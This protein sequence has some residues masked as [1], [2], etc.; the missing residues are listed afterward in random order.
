MTDEEAIQPEP[1]PTSD[2][3]VDEPRRHRT[4]T[5][6]QH[7]VLA[8]NCVIVVVCFAAAVGLIVGKRAAEQRQV[9]AFAAPAVRAQPQATPGSGPVDTGPQETFPAADPAV[10]NFLLVGADNNACIDPKSPYA[11]G[12]ASTGHNG[13]TDTIMVIRVDSGNHRAAVLS[14]PRDLWVDVPGTGKRRI[15]SAYRKNDPSVL[16]AVLHD[17]FAIDIDHFVQVDFCA[18]VH[19]VQAVGG[20]QVPLPYAMRDVSTGFVTEVAGC[21]RFVGDEALA[22]VRSRHMEYQDI[23]NEWHKDGSSDFGR[24]ARQQDFIRR[25]LKAI[26]DGGLFNPTKIQGL[27]TS[28]KNDLV[29]DGDLTVAKI[30]EF[31]GVVR[32]LDPEQI[33]SYQIEADSAKISGNDVLLWKSDSPTMQAILDVFRGKAPLA[34]P[35]DAAAQ[36][37]T[38]VAVAAAPTLVATTGA[39]APVVAAAPTDTAPESNAPK[40]ALVPDPKVQCTG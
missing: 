28:Y 40:T 4:H 20:V 39:P 36:P 9:V 10:R 3:I 6:G 11:K 21:H 33:R 38:T 25:T 29:T 15:N 7:L 26:G 27:Y 37:S 16:Q 30:L 18:F 13:L 5:R 2:S 1:D 24:I 14:F 34:A 35:T 8:L 31:A 22:Y 23:G 32:D 12:L 19:L 17:E